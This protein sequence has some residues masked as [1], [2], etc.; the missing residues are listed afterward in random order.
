[1][2][3]KLISILY[4]S[5]CSFFSLHR[6]SRNLLFAE[7]RLIITVSYF[8]DNPAEELNVVDLSNINHYYGY[9]QCLTVWD[10]S[11]VNSQAGLRTGDQFS[12]VNNVSHQQCAN[13]TWNVP[14][15]LSMQAH[16]APLDITFY[17][18]PPTGTGTNVAVNRNY[19]TH[20]FVSFHGSWNRSPPIGYSVV[21]IPWSG[22]GPTAAANSLTGY[23]PILQAPNLS[24]CPYSCFRPVGLVFDPQGRLFGTSD[25]TGEVSKPIHFLL[26]FVKCNHL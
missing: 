26:V 21:R 2:A 4:V 22:D 3:N 5:L 10:M 17:R 18:A 24:S 14:P 15:R 25:T 12:V 8:Q 7:Q 19:N 9:P 1:M 11:Q 13:K 6:L 23:T 16:S 20:A